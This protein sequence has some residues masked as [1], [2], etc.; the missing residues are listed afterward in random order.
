MTLITD[1]YSDQEKTDSYL[2][3]SLFDASTIEDEVA[4]QA[5]NAKDKINTFLGRK[6]DFTTE[7]LAEVQFAGIVDSASQW[8]AC[9]VQQSTQAAAMSLTED[10]I[11]DCADALKTLKNWALANGITPPSEKKTQGYI[12]TELIYITNDPNEVV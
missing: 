7:E 4:L 11:K 10:T 3:L 2:A 9:L 12:I 1:T 5:V 6:V 8:T